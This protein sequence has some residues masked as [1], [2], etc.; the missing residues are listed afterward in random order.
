MFGFIVGFIVGAAVWAKFG[1]ALWLWVTTKWG[2][3]GDDK[4]VD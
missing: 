3:I 4:P 2:Q 1:T